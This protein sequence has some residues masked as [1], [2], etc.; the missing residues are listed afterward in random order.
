MWW[1]KEADWRDAWDYK[2][3]WTQHH[4]TKEQ[5]DP[6]AYSYDELATKCLDI[7]DELAPPQRPGGVNETQSTFSAESSS[8]NSP[9]PTCC[10]AGTSSSSPHSRDYYSLLRTYHHLDPTLTR[11]WTQLHALPSWVSYDQLSRGQEVFYRYAGPAIAGLT[12]QALLGGMGGYRVVETLSRTGGFSV[13]VAR[14]RLLETFQHILDVTH[15][16][17]SLKPEGEGFTSTIRVRFLHANVR[18]RILALA[19]KAEGKGK[20][21]YDVEKLGV[22]I[23]DLDSMGT[24]AAF[25][26]TLIW[27]SLPRQGIWLSEQEKEDYIALW[28]YLGY[29]LGAPTEP[30]FS[31]P[32]RAKATMESLMLTEI[33][34]SETSQILANNIIAALAD[35][36]PVYTSREFL[37]AESWWLNGPKLSTALAVARPSWWYRVLVGL[38]CA[39]FMAIIYVT[40]AVPRWDKTRILGAKRK[41][42]T[43]TVNLSGG[44]AMHGLQY[45]PQLGRMTKGEDIR[46]DDKSDSRRIVQRERPYRRMVV[47]GG[48]LLSAAAWLSIRYCYPSTSLM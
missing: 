46:G 22:P 1:N 15:D 32:A 37:C 45:T 12:F 14:R 40:R 33:Q 27:V 6:L 10:G 9:T 31:T 21:Y 16:I 8:S 4:L 20:S 7:L 42:R 2:F 26:A 18:R 35:S 29:L 3:R 5:F 19:N 34:P 41:I 30:Y 17:D 24:I 44:K 39:M 43:L 13:R 48:A 25:S 47:V 23:N 38:Q 11:L 28:R 36:P